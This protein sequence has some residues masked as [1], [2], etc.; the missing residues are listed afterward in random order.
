MTLLAIERSTLQRNRQLQRRLLMLSNGPDNQRKLPPPLGRSAP[1]LIHG[2]VGPPKSSF[3]THIDRRVPLLYKGL[4]LPP[5]QKKL[6]ISLGGSG[7]PTNT[8]YLGPT[9]VINQTAFGSVQPFSY[10]SQMP[11]CTMHCQWG[12]KPPKLLIPLGVA[13][14][15]RRRTEPRQ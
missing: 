14:P 4:L 1:H 8:W 12:R 5:P 3:K 11:C 10:G 2:F 6:P 9:K 13:T 15:R 7:P